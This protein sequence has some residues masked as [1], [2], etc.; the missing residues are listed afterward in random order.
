ML[1]SG[2]KYINP[3]T[4]FGFKRIFGSEFNKELLISFLN[5]LFAGERVIINVT[6]KNSEHLGTNEQERRAIFDV[7]CTTDTGA[8][9]IVEMQNVYQEFY[10]DRSIYYST[11]PIS[12]QAKRGDWN[13]ELQDVYTVGILNFT[14]PENKRSDNCVYREIK[15]MDVKSREVFYDKLTYI[16]VELA[17][18][19]RS[20]DECGTVLDKWIYCL[21]NLQNLMSRPSALQERVFRSLFKTAEISQLTTE[22]LRAYELSVNAYR[23]IKNGIDAAKK[24]GM[25]KGMEKGIAI[26]TEKGIAIGTEKGIAI[27][28]EKGIAIGTKNKAVEIARNMAREGIPCSTISKVTGLAVEEIKVLL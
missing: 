1:Q 17:N 10:K 5:A 25:E 6:F 9:I 22:D 11:F 26:G 23:D 21:K 2:E 14:F 8:R 4:D 24:E 27:G 28:T 3:L 13:Y 16:Y 7:Y 18:F 19:H 20:L 15:L 12:E